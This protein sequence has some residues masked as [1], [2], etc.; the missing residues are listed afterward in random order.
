MGR[1]GR[2]VVLTT[3][4]LLAPRS[5]MSRAIPQFPLW[6]LRG[7]LKGDLYLYPLPLFYSLPT[8][9]FNLAILFSY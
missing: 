3:H 2:G 8:P 7:L 9:L 1:G 4:L 6:A 5:I